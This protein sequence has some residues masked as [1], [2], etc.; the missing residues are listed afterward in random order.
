M[1]MHES[2]LLVCCLCFNTMKLWTF[3]PN[4]HLSLINTT[5]CLPCCQFVY[6]LVCLLA[7]LPSCFLFV[8][9]SCGS[10]CLLSYAMLVMPIYFMPLSYALCIFSFHC[11]YIG[12]LSWPLHVHIW[13]ENAQSQGTVSQAQVKGARMRAC[14]YKTSACVQQVQGLASPIWLCTLLNPPFLPPSFLLDGLYQV[15]HAMYHSSSFPEYGNPYLLFL[16]LYFGPCSR[17]VGIY[18][19]TLC[20]CIVHD[21]CIYIPTRP[22]WCDYHSPCHLRQSN[23]QFLSRK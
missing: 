7:C 12:F 3:N 20:A 11:L 2:C 10:L 13:N 8:C 17:D 15:Y 9:L 16:H 1:I 5:F 14:G 18:F 22:F 19:P 4:L 23:A 21:I 6:F